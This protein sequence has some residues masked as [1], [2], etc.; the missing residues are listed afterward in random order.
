MAWPPS[1]LVMIVNSRFAK[2]LLAAMLVTELAMLAGFAKV[3]PS[4]ESEAQLLRRPSCF[5]TLQNPNSR[6]IANWRDLID[7]V[8]PD[9][10]KAKDVI[11]FLWLDKDGQGQYINLDYYALTFKKH[12][13]KSLEVFFLE[14]RQNFAFFTAGPAK[15][16][17]FRAYQSS[18]AE[19]D[20]LRLDNEKR[21]RSIDH[22]GAL[23]SFRLNDPFINFVNIPAEHAPVI[24]G[25][26]KYGDVQSTC[27]SS[28]DFIFSTVQ[29]EES[30]LHPVAGNRGFGIKDNGN[31]TWTFYS[32]AADR[33]SN[34]Q[35]N[36]VMRTVT[37]EQ[38]KK[39]W[40]FFYSNMKDYLNNQGLSVIGEL[41]E[42]TTPLTDWSTARK[43]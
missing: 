41:V 2:G 31:G 1:L 27:V 42:N 36:K 10:S 38:G 28:T 32:K 8:P 22:K 35:M 33:L 12:P 16:Y 39:F 15:K 34:Y 19:N 29:S 25:V 37:F 40:S 14:M 21:W 23:M 11:K 20:S 18:N 30:G 7:Y 17:A 43:N 13:T 3:K 26:Q 6:D 9:T 4:A 24:T 5:T